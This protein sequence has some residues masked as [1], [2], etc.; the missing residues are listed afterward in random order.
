MKKIM[1]LLAGLA[2]ISCGDSDDTSNDDASI[3]PIVGTW[4]VETEN[5]S[6]TIVF[7]PDGTF[8][9]ESPLPEPVTDGFINSE[10]IILSPMPLL[11]ILTNGSWVNTENE[12]YADYPTT[13]EYLISP[14]VITS[15]EVFRRAFAFSDDFN[16]FVIP[17]YGYVH[18]FTYVRQ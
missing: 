16:S 13:Q 5:H 18:G 4:I 9:S 8:I 15:E 11:V 12:N 6:Y 10:T 17:D 7:N 14:N 1:I 2:V 3:D